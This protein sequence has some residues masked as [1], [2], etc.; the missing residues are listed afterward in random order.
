[1]RKQGLSLI[2]CCAFACVPYECSDF[3]D[4]LCANWIDSG[5]KIQVSPTKCTD[6]GKVCSL[7]GVLQWAS[8]GVKTGNYSCSAA[9]EDSGEVGIEWTYAPCVTWTEQQEWR[10]GSTVLLCGSNQDCV[11][12][13]NS[14]GTCICTARSDSQGVC[15]PDPSNLALTAPYWEACAKGSLLDQN[16]YLYWAFIFENW[17]YLQSDLSCIGLFSEGEMYR[18]L[19]E[20]YS[21]A[22]VLAVLGSVLTL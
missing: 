21:S 6:T 11:K 7:L 2:I 22:V 4:D 8:G 20:K 19:T 14:L 1:M 9:V 13:D 3:S 15:F 16:F 5:T 18:Y 10:D 12:K 17:A